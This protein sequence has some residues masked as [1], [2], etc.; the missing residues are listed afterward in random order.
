MHIAT[1]GEPN[2]LIFINN[3]EEVAP[4]YPQRISNYLKRNNRKE[5]KLEFVFFTACHST[6]HAQ[7]A[8]QHIYYSI[9]MNTSVPDDAIILFV[10]TFYELFFN[11]FS[12]E[13]AFDDACSMLKFQEA[14]TYKIPQLYVNTELIAEKKG[15]YEKHHEH[16]SQIIYIEQKK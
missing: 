7:S 8:A 9:G 10:E 14:E 13:D 5:I 2:Q 4:V 12:I 3:K 15:S 11:D 1:H 6:I 16:N